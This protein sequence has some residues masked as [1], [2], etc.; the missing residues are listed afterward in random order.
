VVDAEALDLLRSM[1]MWHKPFPK[2]LRWETV[3]A[4]AAASSPAGEGGPEAKVEGTVRAMAEGMRLGVVPDAATV[5][6]CLTHA[7][8]ASDATSRPLLVSA[9]HAA[10]DAGLNPATMRAAITSS[11]EFHRRRDADCAAH[12]FHALID[13]RLYE[14][15]GVGIGTEEM[16]QLMPGTRVVDVRDLSRLEACFFLRDAVLRQAALSTSAPS[17]PSAPSALSAL[18]AS[19]AVAA[20]RHHHQ[21]DSRAHILFLVSEPAAANSLR[22]LLVQIS[23]PPLR[24]DGVYPHGMSVRA[25]SVQTWASSGGRLVDEHAIC[26]LI[27]A[28]RKER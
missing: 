23:R 19:S 11:F 5:R 2:R 22:S 8:A 1:P 25:E 15:L 28:E 6:H 20:E 17:A 12:L 24:P 10:L 16:H 7:F 27:S 26:A 13:G 9:L 21:G 3:F 18:S 4:Q 14:R